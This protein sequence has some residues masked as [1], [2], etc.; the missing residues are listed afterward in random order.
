M[1]C[2]CGGERL[3]RGTGDRPTLY[4]VEQTWAGRCNAMGLCRTERNLARHRILMFLGIPSS[5]TPSNATL[6]GRS[7]TDGRSGHRLPT[8]SHALHREA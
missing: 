1:A 3:S 4:S 6:P 5:S 7:V 8:A 2:L